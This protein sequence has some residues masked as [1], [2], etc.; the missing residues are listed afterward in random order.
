MSKNVGV[1][2]M[3]FAPGEGMNCFTVQAVAQVWCQPCVMQDLG[4]VYPHQ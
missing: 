2:Q 3:N 1:S 4:E